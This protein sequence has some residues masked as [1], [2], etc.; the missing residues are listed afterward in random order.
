MKILILDF[1]D[2]KVKIIDWI[3]E[4]TQ[5]EEVEELLYEKYNLKVSNIEYMIVPELEIETLN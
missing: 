5:I 2:W 4:G 3:K 1:S